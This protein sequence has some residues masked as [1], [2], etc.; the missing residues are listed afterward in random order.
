MNFP[1]RRER[2]H[3]KSDFDSA[4][5]LLV[6]FM[7]NHCPYVIHIREAFADFVREYQAKGLAVV[8]INAN[9]VEQYP[10][11]SPE[12]MAKEIENV[13]Y[14]FPYLFDE[15]Q[16]VAAAYRAACTPDFFLFDSDR[17]LVYRG[18]FD[19]SRPRTDTPV[20]G[21]DL[22]NAV[23][24][25]LAGEPVPAD[26][27]ASMGCNIKWRADRTPEYAGGVAR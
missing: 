10:A 13:G 16:D 5:A 7:C 8:G 23:D 17:K 26:Q 21:K 24:L 4:D 6:V 12:M 25:V 18:Q 15:S 9:D 1:T 27:K 22:R 14:T 2:S 19:A 11:D 20:T 3:S